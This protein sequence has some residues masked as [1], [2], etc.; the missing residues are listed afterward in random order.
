[1][2]RGRILGGGVVNKSRP[3]ALVLTPGH[4]NV[5]NSSRVANAINK[6]FHMFQNGV[7]IGV[8][9]AKTSEL[10]DLAVHPRY[11]DNITRYMQVICAVPLSETATERMQHIAQLQG[12]LLVPE[13][14][15]DAA[16]ELE[17]IG[18]EGVDALVKG[19]HSDNAEVRFYASEA[20]A[21]LDH[22]EAAE[23][24]GQLARDE[25]AF[26]VFALTALSTLQ[27]YVAYEQ[28]RN[29]LA[30][31][32]AETR[33][34]A[35]RALWAMNKNNNFVKGEMLGEQFHYHVLDVAGPP[36]IHATR[37]QIAE[38][39]LFGPQQQFLTPL[40][41]NAG[42]EIMV[43]SKGGNEIS[44]SK[45]SVRDGDQKRIVSTRV[46]DVIRAI[47]ELGGA[48]PDVV[49]A[50]QEAKT[51][52]VLQ[53]R[54]EIDALPEAGRVYDRVVADNSD[55]KKIADA[56]AAKTAAKDAIAKKNSDQAKEGKEDDDELPPGNIQV[57]KA[58]PTHATSELF[59]KQ[60]GGDDGKGGDL[61][62]A[63]KSSASP[64]SDED[65]D[66][67][68]TKKGFFDRMFGSK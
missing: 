61:D 14:A 34:G 29:L 67:T 26:R 63:K 57:A 13:T 38:I 28:L 22:R 47:A 40:A 4:Q 32:S 10:I 17:A 35:F 60:G 41:I 8:A 30:L 43:T 42:N 3:V 58:A 62:S 39:V 45:Y 6:R 51:A 33:Y 59:S 49:Q 9:T 31:P 55:A 56:A 36:M 64:A 44:V 24:L 11:K 23:P 46:D 25:P 7:K 66:D 20:L 1:M 2:C 5:V 54:F 65:D 27:E 21:Y 48:Y 12:E 50:L 53:T 52:G 19:I 37:T 18:T 16:M 15:E 68:N